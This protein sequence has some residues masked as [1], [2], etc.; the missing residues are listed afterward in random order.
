MN[1]LFAP[2]LDTAT[3]DL[4]AIM[5][6]YGGAEKPVSQMSEDEFDAVAQAVYVKVREQAFSRGLPVI[7]GREGQVLKE[8]ADGRIEVVPS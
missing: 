8:Y 5:P 4:P 1:E 6:L 3:L 7:I 2:I